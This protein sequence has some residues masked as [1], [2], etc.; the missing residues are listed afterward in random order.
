MWALNRAIIWPLTNLAMPSG[1]LNS[2]ISQFGFLS[3][4]SSQGSA[5][6]NS[7]Q[8]APVRQGAD[9]DAR[10]QIVPAPARLLPLRFLLFA[11][12]CAHSVTVAQATLPSRAKRVLTIGESP[13]DLEIELLHVTSG[14][15]LRDGSVAFVNGGSRQIVLV[16][17]KT[18]THRMFG[19][20]GSGP[21][22]FGSLMFLSRTPGDSI[23]VFDP[24]ARRFSVFSSQGRLLASRKLNVAIDTIA[25]RV[26][27]SHPV[28]AETGEVLMRYPARP[29]IDARGRNRDTLLLYAMRLS[30]S[31]LRR[32]GEFGR[33][34]FTT[35]IFGDPPTNARTIP[36]MKDQA[37]PRVLR[38]TRIDPAYR[39]RFVV[40]VG[41]NLAV[42]SDSLNRIDIRDRAGRTIGSIA[43]HG[44]SLPD[45]LANTK[46]PPNHPSVGLGFVADDKGRLWVERFRV[47]A[48]RAAVWD[49]YRTT[50]AFVGSVE[51]PIASTVMAIRGNLVL[52]SHLTEDQLPVVNVF[53]FALP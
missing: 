40:P 20:A 32:V 1:V 2:R 6:S 42:L 19:R 52:G 39:R 8:R 50:G 16:D 3:R 5:S 13:A 10:T 37:G 36:L 30:D 28:V 24:G 41:G 12:L 15:I 49:V 26:D 9:P 38:E 35:L 18:R 46:F 51:L 34:A 48:D 44:R 25:R 23:L 17:P 43:L 21:G 47:G 27:W 22:E 29:H 4:S 11:M 45:Y 31:T 53:R 33:P 7:I 14:A